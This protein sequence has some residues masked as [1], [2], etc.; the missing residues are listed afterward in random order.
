MKERRLHGDDDLD[1]LRG[2]LCVGANVWSKRAHGW[3]D[4]GDTW[5][6]GHTSDGEN[7][8]TDIDEGVA[9]FVRSFEPYS[10]ETVA[11]RIA[12]MADF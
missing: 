11:F 2:S 4:S 10:R 5:S 8:R 9:P 6:T 7:E 3:P 12:T 1:S